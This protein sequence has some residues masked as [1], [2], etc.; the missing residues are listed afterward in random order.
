VAAEDN[1]KLGET[2]I[3]PKCGK[4]AAVHETFEPG[5]QV[6]GRGLGDPDATGAKST[7]MEV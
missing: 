4:T 2:K 5:Q 6:V 1:A 3:Y 7:C